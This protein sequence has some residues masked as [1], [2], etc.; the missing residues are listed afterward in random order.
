MTMS[1]KISSVCL[2]L[3]LVSVQAF[4]ITR[5]LAPVRDN[6]LYE[7]SSAANALS[8]GA[9][10]RIF[11]GRTAQ[12]TD[13][14]RRALVAF[15]PAGAAIP[16][17]AVITSATLTLDMNM[18]NAGSE[19][20]SIHRVLAN[21]GEGGSSA[22]G[23]QGAGAP[24]Q[25]G[26]ATWFHTLFSASFWGSP[27]GDFSGA[28]SATQTVGG[29]GSYTWGSTTQMVADVQSWV[30]NPSSNFGWLLIGNEASAT[31]AKSFD[32]RE[33]GNGPALV[34]TFNAPVPTTNDWALLL[35]A[36]L[37]ASLGVL[38]LRWVSV[39]R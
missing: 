31:T 21:W 35:L 18:T 9:G 7:V 14:I 15:D 29:N 22:G 16:S 8:N 20:I 33:S 39:R 10:T 24:A 34:V 2:M 6:T 4:A 27:G 13:S 26:D 17:G 23:G 19:A 32:S 36:L 38:S 12:G 25:T 11:A 30:D 1:M 28:P 3:A 5:T 37:L